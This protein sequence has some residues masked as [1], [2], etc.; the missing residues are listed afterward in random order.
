MKVL[1]FGGRTYGRPLEGK[2]A[3]VTIGEQQRLFYTLH[4]QYI[5]EIIHGGAPGADSLAGQWAR[6]NAIKET[7]VKADWDKHGRA[8]GP[9]R[10][11]EMLKLSPDKA[12]GFPGGKG[13]ADM[14]RKVRAAGIP[15]EVIS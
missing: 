2:P 3:G 10:N 1:V 4:G 12:F 9:I 15:L 5:T 13:T 11:S 7:C 14:V 6:A 8:A